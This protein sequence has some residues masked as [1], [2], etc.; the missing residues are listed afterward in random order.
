MFTTSVYMYGLINVS[1]PVDI[2]YI[3]PNFYIYMLFLNTNKH[4]KKQ[5]L[6][7]VNIKMI[8]KQY[9]G[10]NIEIVRIS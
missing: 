10:S 1:Y 9:W 8:S 6:C 3:I 4:E 2:V 5:N 7:A